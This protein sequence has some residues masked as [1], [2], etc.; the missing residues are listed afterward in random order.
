MDVTVLGEGPAVLL[1]V[2]TAITEGEAADRARAWG[3]GQ[4]LGHALATGLVEAGFQ[5]IAA[6][7]E[8]HLR[9]HPRPDD[10]DAG[11]LAGDLLGIADAA[12]VERFAY[13]G[14]SWLGLAGLQLAIRTDRLTAVAMGGFPPL[15]GPYEAMLKVTHATHRAAVEQGSEPVPEAEPGDWDAAGISLDPDQTRQ[16]VTLYESLRGF[17]E[18]AALAGVRVPRLAFAGADDTIV[19]SAKW[20]DATVVIGDALRRN[21]AELIALGWRVRVIEKA[22]HL[23]AMQAAQVL[24]ILIPFLREATGGQVAAIG[25]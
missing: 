10:L 3:A 18:R 12:G 24:P 9:A 16:Y 22:D 6:D 17:D 20:G 2:G 1:P 11:A 14:Y 13:Y 19:Y 7:Y 4:N 15:D 25:S 23:V 8:A 21:A 5:V